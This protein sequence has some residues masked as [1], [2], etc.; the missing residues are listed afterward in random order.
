MSRIATSPGRAYSSQ[1]RAQQAEETRSRILDAT[2]RV[3]AR[4]VGTLSIPDVARE[5]RVSVP[6]VYRHFGT[7][8]A[9]L[10]AVHPHLGRRAGIGEVIEPTSVDE[11]REMVRTVFSRLESLGEDARVAM[12]GPAADEARRGQMP[13]RYAMSRR[14][15]STV[16]PDLDEADRDRLARVLI[17]LASSG[18]MRTW[19]D[20]L[21]LS[22]D[23]AAED[24]HWLLRTLTAPAPK[25]KN[26]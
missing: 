3:M 2:I 11:F 4:G 8:A 5:A 26:R 16:M 19:R 24:I 20:H 9:L 15:A 7:K 23:V 12:S 10:T 21:G 1:L 18:A 22:V 17:V 6:T 25:R 14:F 13:Q